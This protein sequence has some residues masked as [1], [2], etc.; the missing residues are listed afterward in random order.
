MNGADS[1]A[2]MHDTAASDDTAASRD[3]TSAEHHCAF[4]VLVS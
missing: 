4:W 2:T 3:Q 1:A